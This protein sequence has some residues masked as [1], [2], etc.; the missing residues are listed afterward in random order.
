[1]FKVN[2]K[3]TVWHRSGVC[4]EHNSHLVLEFPLLTL[5]MYLPVGQWFQTD[6]KQEKKHYE[7]DLLNSLLI[8]NNK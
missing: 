6:K 5:N 4:I 7:N 2:N 3:D 8:D 1:M